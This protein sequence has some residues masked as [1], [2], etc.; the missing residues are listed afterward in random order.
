MARQAKQNRRLTVQEW[1]VALVK[2][3]GVGQL[4]A[5]A[6]AVK[7]AG[8]GAYAVPAAAALMRSDG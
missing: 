5:L 6:G 8:G 1:V 4:V 2:K 7:Q 3:A